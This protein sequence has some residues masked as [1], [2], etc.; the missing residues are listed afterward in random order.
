MHN[1][2]INDNPGLFYHPD[3]QSM[4]CREAT[5]RVVKSVR[6]QNYTVLKRF[7]EELPH[8]KVI[9]LFRDPRAV[10]LSR[11]KTQSFLN[12]TLE[13][14]CSNLNRNVIIS[15][16][17]RKD[18]PERVHLLRQE[19]FALNPLKVSRNVLQFLGLRHNS[20]T[21]SFIRSHMLEVPAGKE[22]EQ[23]LD[24]VQQSSSQVFRWRQETGMD[25]VSK[26][27]EKCSIAMRELGYLK[28]KSE[29]E[30][31]DERRFKTMKIKLQ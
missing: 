23:M 27:Q 16:A 21:L 9:A 19:D 22:P 20:A 5:L 6:V 2:V 24:T 28:V 30:L 3:L 7:L 8:L 25:L 13:E 4:M 26:V 15:K 11:L 29:A 14:H 1:T 18:Y 17:L 31:K 10:H 12:Q